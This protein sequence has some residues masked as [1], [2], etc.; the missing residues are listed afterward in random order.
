M[1]SYC[2]AKLIFL[3]ASLP[4]RENLVRH[5]F[6]FP[7]ESMISSNSGFKALYLSSGA[8]AVIVTNVAPAESGREERENIVRKCV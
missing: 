4:F 7:Y 6:S 3:I 8:C 5:Y 2:S 1:S